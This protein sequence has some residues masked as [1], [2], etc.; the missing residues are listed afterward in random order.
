MG[1][2]RIGKNGPPVTV[3]EV[4][5]PA[6]SHATGLAFQVPAPTAATPAAATSTSV[7][8]T[9][10]AGTALERLRAGEIDLGGYV[11]Q[12]VHEATAHLSALPPVE[13]EKIRGALRER[14][15]SDPTLVD[16][17]QTATGETLPSQDD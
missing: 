12:K 16:L 17:L 11:D 6:G 1:I 5:G 8:P 2:D 15:A 14:L 9:R 10:A 13:L 4:A 3:P 7:D